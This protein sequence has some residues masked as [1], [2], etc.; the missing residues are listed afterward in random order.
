MHQSKMV[1]RDHPAGE[2][3][4][5]RE[6][7]TRASRG[8]RTRASVLDSQISHLRREPGRFWRGDSHVWEGI[9]QQDPLAGD[10]G[11]I[12]QVAVNGPDKPVGSSKV[13]PSP[14]AGGSCVPLRCERGWTRSWALLASKDAAAWEAR[15]PASGQ[16]GRR[17]LRV[18]TAW[19]AE[20]ALAPGHW[21]QRALADLFS[22]LSIV[23]ANLHKT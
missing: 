8:A 15:L 16:V 23:P 3:G 12:P 4:P 11:T 17:R 18:E 10:V 14:G 19:L 7:L 13:G 5:E 6:T 22:C 2:R 9:S 20:R 1:L 21:W